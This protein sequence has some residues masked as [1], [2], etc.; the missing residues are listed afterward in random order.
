MLSKGQENTGLQK[1]A[2]ETP[3]PTNVLPVC[4]P[5]LQELDNLL[6]VGN[7]MLR[8]TLWREKRNHMK[9]LVN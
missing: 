5:C 6:I 3:H 9:L 2:A 8:Q 4:Y 1:Q 7:N